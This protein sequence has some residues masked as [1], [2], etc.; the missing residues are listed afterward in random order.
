MG[1][2]KEAGEHVKRS[3]STKGRRWIKRK[4][5]VVLASVHSLCTAGGCTADDWHTS[6]TLSWPCSPRVSS[7]IPDV[8][9][10]ACVAHG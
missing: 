7:C 5:L 4:G 10:S 8:L 6:D 2:R 9:Q 1:G 3:I